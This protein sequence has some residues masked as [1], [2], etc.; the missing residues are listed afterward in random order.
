MRARPGYFLLLSLLACSS[1]SGGRL[2]VDAGAADAPGTGGVWDAWHDEIGPGPGVVVTPGSC[3]TENEAGVGKIGARDYYAA[4]PS[5]TF[6]IAVRLRPLAL[7][8]PPCPGQSDA[9]ARCAE[10][11]QALM[12][13]QAQNQQQFACVLGSFGPPRSVDDL[14]PLWY[15]SPHHLT[16]GRPVPIGVEFIVAANWAQ[17]QAVAAHPF[18][19][20]IDP[21]PG[22]APLLKVAA[23]APPGECPAPTDEP[24]RKLVDAQIQNQGQRG[25]AIELREAGALPPVVNCPGDTLCEAGVANMWDRAILA[26]RQR[27][28]VLRYVDTVVKTPAASVSYGSISGSPIAPALPPFGQAAAAVRAFGLG[29]TW[30]DLVAVARLPD[31][32]RIWSGDGLQIDQPAPGCPPDL[33]APIASPTCSADRE[34]ATGKLSAAD[35]SRIATATQP[36][37]I[38]IGVRDGAHICPLPTCPGPSQPCPTRD[39]YISRWEAEN[40]ESQRCVRAFIT[41]L[42]GTASAEIFWLV[43]FVSATMPPA[44]IMQLA[45]HPHVAN[46][47]VDV[48]TPPP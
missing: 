12:E 6:I 1:G 4:H 33:T 29:L 43:N 34:A 22:Q 21:A 26:L 20:R 39:A 15:E 9:D 19:A 37:S 18:V 13:R 36:L 5:E 27:T 31:V 25:V 2:P 7:A 14:L 47:S 30:E 10:R 38:S 24:L 23:P 45:T 48:P 3:P 42:G 11:D 28:C 32:Q 16:S 8:I 35:L 46:I 41:E 44:Q 17:V 40:R